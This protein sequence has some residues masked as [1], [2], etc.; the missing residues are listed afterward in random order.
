MLNKTF[1]LFISSTFSDFILERNILN[2]EIFP[3]V[4]DYCQQRGYNFQLIDL[5]WGV[6]NESALN[7][8]TIAICLD[9]V[10]RCR[11]LSPKPNFLVMAGERYGWI[12]LP[13]KISKNDF[14]EI[15]S[16]ATSEEK[17][18]ITEWYILD[19]NEIG[20]EFYLKTRSGKYVDDELWFQTESDV[21]NAL[22]NCVVNKL[23]MSE[24]KVRLITS[25][26]TE[27]EIFEGL[28]DYKGIS[29][30]TI[31]VFR[32]NYPERDKNQEKIENLKRRI[33]Q[34]M[35]EDGCEENI[36]NLEWNS[37]YRDAFKQTIVEILLK[38]ISLEIDRLSK[39]IASKNNGEEI[40]Q[41][42]ESTGF[43][44]DRPI[45]KE[46]IE[47]Y[48]TG[49]SN[50]PLFLYG[51]SGSGK[52]TLLAQFIKNDKR[53]FFHAFYGWGENHYTLLSSIED[54]I[55]EIKEYY[56]I[57]KEFNVNEFNITESF[58]SALYAI[59]NTETAVI[60]LDGFD[61]FHDLEEIKEKV[62][63][64]NLPSNIK[65]IISSADKK[66]IEKY[67]DGSAQKI[68]L[69]WFDKKM[70]KENFDLLLMQKN[71]CIA[72]KSQVDLVMKAINDGTTP[73]QLKLMTEECSGWHSQDVLT[74][75][76]NSVETIANKHIANMYLKYGHNKELV[77]HAL[78]LI[79]ASPYGITE[80]ELQ[81]LLL[82][83][84]AV[85][86]YFSSEDRYNHQM[87]KL[88]FVVWSR[89]F[90]DL[91][92]CLT[93][94]RV[95]G[96]IVVKF[97]HQ[98]FYKVFLDLY[99]DY[100][101]N[102]ME[103]LISFYRGQNNYLNGSK[104]PNVRRSLSLA[105][106]LKRSGKVG[107]L[108]DL[109]CDL[110][111][112][113]AVVKIGDVNKI[114]SD[115]QFG[116]RNSQNEHQKNHLSQI[117][118]CVQKNRNML[119]CYCN[120]FYTCVN[121]LVTVD[122]APIMC[123]EHTNDVEE[124][125]YF[126]YSVNS[127]ICWSE[128]GKKYAVY[129]NSYVYI[130]NGE[131]NAEVCRI[132]LEPNGE[133]ISSAKEVLWLDESIVAVITYANEVLVYDFGDGTPNIISKFTTCKDECCIR[134]SKKN[135][136]L[137]LQEK[138]RILAKSIVTGEELFSVKL[139]HRY[140]VFFEIDEK[141]GALYVKDSV[142]YVRIFD[143][144]NGEL[145]N[146][147]RI[148]T[149]YGYFEFFDLL[150][151]SGVHKINDSKWF[152]YSLA[153]YDKLTVY[154]TVEKTRWHLH[155]PY[156]Y[157]SRNK[158]IGN[159]YFLLT[160]SNALILVDLYEPFTMQWLSLPNIKDASWKERDKSIS[161]INDDGLQIF[162]TNDFC[163]FSQEI[164]NCMPLRKNLFNSIFLGVQPIIGI[165]KNAAIP[166]MKM[167]RNMN[168]IMDYDYVFSLS[169]AEGID[170]SSVSKLPS[171]A[172]IAVTAE[173]GKIAVAYEEENTI[174]VYNKDNKPMLRIDKL[175]LSIGNDVLKMC[176]SPDSNKL[177]IWRN[178]SLQII[179]VC[180]GKT[181]LMLDTEWRPV[182]NAEF[183]DD[184]EQIK[185]ILCDGQEYL[186]SL[187]NDKRKN[188]SALPKKLVSETHLDAYFG[189]YSYYEGDDGK[190]K[191]YIYL[192]TS[193]FDLQTTPN[194]WFKRKRL[195]HG[196]K[197]WLFFKNGEFYLNGDVQKPFS[198]ELYNFDRCMQMEILR[199]SKPIKCYLRE[200][201]DLFSGIIELK[202]RYLILVSRMLN[203]II[204][205]D[206]EQMKVLSAY[207][208]DGN[209]IGYRASKEENKI[210]VT[211]DR[212]PYQMKI[213][214]NL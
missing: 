148:K 55:G 194:H 84:E 6:N 89:L 131:S 157:E 211:I 146:K 166:L 91:K 16:V 122:D 63:P 180:N 188:K 184:S 185:M 169:S 75:L 113:D 172:S 51:D 117:Y 213:L 99:K 52:T 192:D 64:S 38:N 18:I 103:L 197:Y 149:K 114:A 61:M 78:A 116:I 136:C 40:D 202:E 31:A 161:V 98:V 133:T 110:S 7:Q 44:L 10:K 176:F 115:L 196:K 41:I 57:A 179:D 195:Y 124:T 29:N 182:L 14:Y 100:Y 26:A 167:L 102:A 159:R 4:D 118:K 181:V 23:N 140:N 173:D 105:I 201:N 12:P 187:S 138:N 17:K 142:K 73:L 53:K 112:V 96:F 152:V 94:S 204:V 5:R 214:I 160:Y 177:L 46:K 106:L 174:I 54:I 20:G 37:S 72:P 165:L 104:M 145:I 189:P 1:R 81:V 209:I 32:T 198:H 97:A 109:L 70:S 8:N 127:K 143:A 162:S 85:R 206:I 83:F 168:N 22:K 186:C 123:V 128:G 28:L 101:M 19:E 207:K 34:K 48:L 208:V 35:N 74:E 60:V 47:K 42:I 158:L 125:V 69:D 210:Y 134:Y 144:S 137:Y 154:D 190:F 121:G 79:A 50:K 147:K 88:P 199:E 49:D 67:S 93:L 183:I 27:Q 120:E 92:G 155:P 21:Y 203:S 107:E 170:I 2:D 191:T 87:D 163:S 178:D 108:I 76:S 71:R 36:L 65:L 3:I 111:Y 24:E 13:A 59:P 135:N 80:E 58:F 43:I 86:N 15:M 200:K 77:L 62:I 151:G 175:K 156:Y 66:I 171:L 30:N 130:C 11:T 126:P 139:K 95:K 45:E 90:Y 132:Y 39:E 56:E 141:E 82:K 25:S 164:D 9:E 205:F 68:D 212:E 193:G 33:I 129:S 150:N 153:L 119:S